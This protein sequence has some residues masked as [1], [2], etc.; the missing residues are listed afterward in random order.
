MHGV[1]TT[2]PTI[3]QLRPFQNSQVIRRTRFTHGMLNPENDCMTQSPPR[4]PKAKLSA[5]QKMAIAGLLCLQIPAGAIFFPA[6]T[7]IILT[8][9]GAPISMAL[10][11]IGSMP[12]SLAMQRKRA[13]QAGSAGDAEA[14]DFPRVVV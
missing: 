3:R 12:F 1:A 8:G 14:A 6:A 13:W 4:P 9:V 5:K 11:A 10:W 7:I 2:L